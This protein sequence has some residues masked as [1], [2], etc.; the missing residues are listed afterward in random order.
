MKETQPTATSFDDFATGMTGNKVGILER[1]FNVERHALEAASIR[2]KLIEGENVAKYIQ[3]KI[4]IPD[5]YMRKI[6]DVSRG[7]SLL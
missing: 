4:R 7:Q 5:G 3:S 1:L 2:N 6:F